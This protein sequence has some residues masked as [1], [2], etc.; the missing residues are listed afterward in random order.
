MLIP[1]KAETRVVVLRGK[2]ALITGSTTG[3]GFA[4]ADRLAAEGCKIVLNGIASAEDAER[5][6]SDLAARHGTEV[7]FHDADLRDPAQIAELMRFAENLGAVAILVNNAVVRHFAAAENFP[8]ERWNEALAVNLSA[9]FHTIRLALPGMRRQD[10]GR[11]INIA[12]IYSFIGAVNRVDYVTTKTAI[13]GLTRAIALET[14]KTNITCN[15][16]APGVL[17]TS[18]ILGRIEDVA[19][20]RNISKAQ[21]TQDY[22][23]DRQP[24][25][26]FI[27]M[28]NVAA[29]VAFLCGPQ[30]QG[31]TGS[32]FPV[33]GGWAIS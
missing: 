19:V 17:P 3:L 11:I 13:L 24:G 20:E 29:M 4:I 31:V 21:A 28:E 10:W 1:S 14:V 25:G 6:R 27:P 15:A 7:R 8:V 5:A 22:L 32:V 23:K 26:R 12:S 30:S 9:A 33:D 18:A 2:C 16:V